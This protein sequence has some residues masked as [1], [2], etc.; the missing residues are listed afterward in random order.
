ML[1][2]LDTPH[3][4][5]AQRSAA[6]P[7]TLPGWTLA[8]LGAQGGWV[9][10]EHLCA[11]LWPDA[12]TSEAQHNLR[13]NLYRVRALLDGWG[14][15]AAFAAERKRVRLQLPTDLALLRQALAAKDGPAALAGYRQPL[16]ADMRCAGFPALQEWLEVERA[17][18]HRQWRQAA[19]ASL[20]CGELGPHPAALLCQT[21]MAADPL[22][23]EALG[24]QLRLC[25]EGGQV[26]DARLLFQQFRLRLR[27]ELGA[28]PT[29]ALQSWLA[30]VSAGPPGPPGS[31]QTG[32]ARDG[33][34]GRALELGQ[35]EAM[36]AGG[37]G[38][39]VTLIGPGGVGKSRLAREI[40]RRGAGVLREGGHDGA[41]DGAAWVNL[42]DLSQAAAAL[43]RLAAQIGLTLTAQ[44]DPL[45]QIAAALA[46]RQ[47]LIVLDNAEHLD[48]L[49][50][51]LAQLQCAAPGTTWLVTSRTPLLL[52]HERTYAL[53]GL[54][55]PEPG[56]QV[57]DA[58]DALRFDAVRL[59]QARAL[60]L[61]PDFDISA[62]W[63]A[64][65]AL[66][67]A[68]GGWPLAIE[69]AA[70]ALVDGDAAAVLADL[71]QTIDTL[72]A[73]QPPQ[74]AR[75]ASMQASLALSWRLL[76][77]GRT[78]RSLRATARRTSRKEAA[79]PLRGWR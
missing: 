30:A 23:E 37:C 10:R 14:A 24:H 11:L 4:S 63:A 8:F 56:E 32:P 7:H 50:A 12:G 57:K 78:G 43:P 61:N 65:V 48:D 42:S 51:L 27:Q 60:A 17:A 47:G 58:A 13:V 31:L 18:L 34:V 73:S 69:L 22:D 21:L 28:D 29:P 70:A 38:R 45:A 1:Y 16:L 15:T 75:H 71:Q 35:V 44:P 74:H 6:L 68:V 5:T 76:G 26:G 3:W 9:T 25:V 49:P 39:I 59:L 19:L 54:G 53:E 36:L 67:G 20:S 41:R 33:F 2:L 62:Q 64:C 52:A 72:A 40:T 77:S 55:R 79:G 46:T 66:V